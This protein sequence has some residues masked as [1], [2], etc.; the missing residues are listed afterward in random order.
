MDRAKLFSEVVYDLTHTF[1]LLTIDQI[2]E[3]GYDILDLMLHIK[4]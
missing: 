4:R 1:I 3:K 2:R